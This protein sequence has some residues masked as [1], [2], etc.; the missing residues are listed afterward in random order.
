MSSKLPNLFITTLAQ[1]L[2]QGGS[3]TEFFLSSITTFDGQIVQT[4][5]FAEWGRGI[6]IVDPQSASRAEFMSFTSVSSGNVSFQGGIRGLSSKDNTV[7]TANK[8]FHPVGATVIISFGTHN[9]SDMVDKFADIGSSEMSITGLWNFLTSPTV[10]TA[11]NPTEAVNLAQLQAATQSGGVDASTIAKGI[12][13]L[14]VSPNKTLG[15]ATITQASPAVV[16]LASHGL[17]VNDTIQFTTTGTLPLPFTAGTTYY[18]ISAGLTSGAFE[19]ALTLGGTAINTTTAGSGTHTL[20]RSTPYVVDEQDGR[21]PTQAENDAMVSDNTDIPVG[22]GNKFMSQTGFQK[23]AEIYGVSTGSATNTISGNPTITIASPAVITLASHGLAIGDAVQFTTTGALP[24]GMIVST[25]YYVIATGFTTGA[26]E[27]AATQGGTAINTTGSQSG[28]HTALRPANNYNLTVSP[29]P[30]SLT[31]PMEFEMKAN[32][33]NTGIATM[34]PNNLGSYQLVKGVNSPIVAGDILINQVYKI[35]FD[36]TN[37]IVGNPTAFIPVYPKV[38]TVTINASVTTGGTLQ[39]IAE[40]SGLTGD[41]DDMYELDFEITNTQ[42]DNASALYILLNNDQSG[43]YDY[44]VNA[45]ATVTAA[46]AIPLVQASA[47]IGLKVTSGKVHIKASKT[48]AG[49]TRML[50]ID[51]VS[52]S[53]T[54]TLPGQ[55]RTVSTWRD[56]TNQL[57]AVSLYYAQT[58]GSTSTTTGFVTLSKIS[59]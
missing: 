44:I 54:G 2:A 14:T 5:D 35:K 24:T 39:K 57:T 15:T 34:N 16:S 33:T 11:V 41:T 37:L 18:V 55:F 59:R 23:R 19:L 17:T 49:V 3:E 31:V 30:I 12:S 9:I 52:G 53:I 7:I 10:P 48:I 27:I 25:T 58:S 28:T 50:I 46:T 22:T 29:A 40:F 45:A 8:K 21:L 4:S 38:S 1:T 32:F 43:T 13:R 47:S 51:A 26:F 20:I 42:A 56:V 36:G 6:I